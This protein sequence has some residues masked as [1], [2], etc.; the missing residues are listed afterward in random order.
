MKNL[1]VMRHSKSDW[2]NSSLSDF[3]RPLNDRGLK[4]APLMGKELLKRNKVPDLIISSPANRAKTTAILAA[5]ACGYND[6]II[7]DQEFYFGSMD[8][9]IKTIIKNGNH[10]QTMMIVGHNPTSE[11]LIY[12]LLRGQMHIQMPTAAIASILFDIDDWRELKAKTGDLEW[13][14][15]PKGLH[16]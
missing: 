7:Y 1:L 13:L 15:I 6:T 12:R 5:E 3:D 8:E 16:A 2:E 9:I 14:I 11:S 4:S 10:H